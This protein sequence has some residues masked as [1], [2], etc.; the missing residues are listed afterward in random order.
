[1]PDEFTVTPSIRDIDRLLTAGLGLQ[2]S[3]L[4]LKQGARAVFRVGKEFLPV[5]TDS[6]RAS[7][8]QKLVAE[9]LLPEDQLELRKEGDVEVHLAYPPFD[10]CVL[11]VFLSSGEPAVVAQFP[12]LP[13]ER[14]PA[15]EVIHQDLEEPPESTVPPPLPV[16]DNAAPRWVGDLQGR[17]RGR[18]IP[19]PW[20]E[21]DGP[22]SAGVFALLPKDPPFKPRPALRAAKP[23]PGPDDGR[24]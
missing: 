14:P 16:D 24:K 6:L 12:G 20:E 13:V 15:P 8:I 1:M 21:E 5:S 23:L 17:V 7:E 22:A 9:F 19:S 10:F 2:A 3:Q 11:H 4:L 18:T